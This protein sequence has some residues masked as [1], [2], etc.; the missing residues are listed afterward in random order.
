M[1]GIKE[2]INEDGSRYFAFLFKT[3]LY[4]GELSSSDEGKVFWVEK[5]EVLQKDWI[6]HMDGFMQVMESS[7]AELFL[8]S[9]D[10]WKQILK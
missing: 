4:S 9:A 5:D 2:W 6:W 3:D 1:C 8:D 10:D 7:P